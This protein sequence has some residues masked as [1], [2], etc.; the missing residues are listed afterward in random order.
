MKFELQHD[1][2]RFVFCICKFVTN[3]ALNTPAMLVCFEKPSSFETLLNKKTL[4]RVELKKN[5]FINYF[6]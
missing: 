3:A 1:F 5:N 2:S 4:L 6:K